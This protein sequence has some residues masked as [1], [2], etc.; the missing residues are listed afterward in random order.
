[1]LAGEIYDPLDPELGRHAGALL[2][3]NNVLVGLP[4]KF[5]PQNCAAKS[6]AR[7][8]EKALIVVR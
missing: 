4:F 1:M 6:W 8:T 7:M 3:G 5:T 2:D